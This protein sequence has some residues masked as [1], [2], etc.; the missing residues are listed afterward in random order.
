MCSLMNEQS[1]GEGDLSS[2]IVEIT[3][4]TQPVASCLEG[5]VKIKG[6]SLWLKVHC[7]SGAFSKCFAYW[8][9][10]RMKTKTE[11]LHPL[12]CLTDS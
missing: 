12:R 5:N 1:H 10:Q 6:I 8:P 7:I 3:E 11:Y 9:A 4:V 2:V